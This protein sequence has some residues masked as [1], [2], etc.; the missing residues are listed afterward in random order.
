MITKDTIIADI[1]KMRPDAAE[2]LMSY[3]MGCI[4]CPSAQMERLEQ[5]CEIHGLD[6]KEVL[7]KLNN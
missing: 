4:G 3:G 5:A 6:L 7:N 2:I 1:I